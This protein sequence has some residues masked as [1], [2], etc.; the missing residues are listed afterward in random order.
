MRELGFASGYAGSSN[1]PGILLADRLA[2]IAPG[3][4]NATYF[5]TGGA[6]SNETAFKVARFYWKMNGRP[7]K[8]KIIGRQ[9]GYHGLTA[10]AMSATGIRSFWRNFDPLQ[11]G[12]HHIPIHYCFRC[13]YHMSYPQCNVLCADALEHQILAEDPET[14]A[15]FVAEP[16]AGT[17]GVLVPPPEYFPRIRETCDKYNVLFIADEVITGFGRTGTMFGLEQWGVVPDMM[18]FAKGVTSGYQPLGGVMLSE[19]LFRTFQ[20]LPAD[21]TFSHGYT[22]S[23]HPVCCAVAL[24]NL[25]II[26]QEGL[27]GRAAAMGSRLMAGL[28]QLESL[29]LGGRGA[30]HWPYGRGGTGRG[31]GRGALL[32][33]C[34]CQGARVYGVARADPP[35]KRRLHHAR[36]AA[37]HHGGADRLRGQHPGRGDLGRGQVVV[38]QAGERGG[39][40]NGPAP[41][42]SGTHRLRRD[43]RPQYHVQQDSRDEPRERQQHEDDPDQGWVDVEVLCDSSRDSADDPLSS[44]SVQLLSHHPPPPPAKGRERVGAICVPRPFA[45]EGWVNYNTPIARRLRRGHLVSRP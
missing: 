35:D 13:P 20:E 19:K 33:G 7:D 6:E 27:V 28:K 22:Y 17:G 29:S 37:D 36:A 38:R 43:D 21:V 16:V 23:Q 41:A 39:D 9:K 42:P 26:E 10:A 11:A 8:V 30:R 32:G 25:D 4:L 1:V 31:Q 12:F 14:I 45:H 40:P 15:A 18:S 34:Q 24:R 3:D 2:K 44:R 5:T